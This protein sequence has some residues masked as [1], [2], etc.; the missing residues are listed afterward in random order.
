MPGILT[1]DARIDLELF[2]G[3]EFRIDF[4]IQPEGNIWHMHTMPVNLTNQVQLIGVGVDRHVD[5]TV[6]GVERDF[7]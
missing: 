7:R 6:E 3:A 5:V 2:D 4:S 1:H